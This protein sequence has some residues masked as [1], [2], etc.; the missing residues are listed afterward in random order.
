[1]RAENRILCVLIPTLLAS[2]ITIP[3]C[4]G[5]EY[6]SETRPNALHHQTPIEK[7]LQNRIAEEQKKFLEISKKKALD[8]VDP[9]LEVSVLERLALI[10]GSSSQEYILEL[11]R[12]QLKQG[13]SYKEKVKEEIKH[14][15]EIDEKSFGC[16]QASAL[17]EL[18]SSEMKI[19]LKT[20]SMYETNRDYE[21]AV[22]T[23]EEIFGKAPEE[24]T[25]RLRFYSMMGNIEGRE[26]EAIKGL[27]DIIAEDPYDSVNKMNAQKL[28]NNFT[29]LDKANTALGYLKNNQNTMLSEKLL[30]EAIA[31]T[32][33]RDEAAYWTRRLNDIRYYRYLDEADKAFEKHNLT[34]AEQLYQKASALNYASP[35]AYIGL[36][37]VSIEKHNET[38]FI[39]YANK[40]ILSSKTESVR[41]QHRIRK[42]MDGL[43]GKII[44]VKAEKALHEGDIERYIQ[45]E[46]TVATIEDDPWTYYDFAK[47]LLELNKK[48]EAFKIFDS[49]G[50]KKLNSKDFVYPYALFL[51]KADEDEQALS[52]LNRHQGES[53]DIEEMRIRLLNQKTVKDS[54]ILFDEGRKEEAY[55]LLEQ[56]STGDTLLKKAEFLAKDGKYDEAEKIIDNLL[57]EQPN[58]PD[59]L[60]N[61]IFLDI[62]QNNLAEAKLNLGKLQQEDNTLSFYQMKKYADYTDATGDKE[63]AVKIYHKIYRQFFPDALEYTP[64]K[65]GSN[66]E[67]IENEINGDKIQ[68]QNNG[69]ELSEK[70]KTELIILNNSYSDLISENKAADPDSLI[71]LNKKSLSLLTGKKYTEDNNAQ[72]T[73]DLRTSDHPVDYYVNTVKK[74][75]HKNYQQ[76]NV[77]ITDGLF[78]TL[79][80][81]HSGYSDN[82]ILTNVLNASFPLGSARGAIQIDTVNFDAG[83]LSNKSYEDA[84]GMCRATGC[85]NKKQSRTDSTVAFAYD[86]DTIH[87]DI[88]TAPKV[89]ENSFKNNDIVGAFQYK[90]DI[91]NWTIKPEIHRRA[92]DNSLLSYYGQKDPKFGRRWGGVKS[93]GLTLGSSYYY[94]QDMGFWSSVTFNTLRGYNVEN[95]YEIKAVAGI[96]KHLEDKPNE[97]LTLSPSI[98]LWHFNKNLSEY[99]YGH[100]GYYSPQKYASTSLTLSYKKRTQNWSYV[101]EGSGAIG[102][103]HKDD[104]NRYYKLSLNNSEIA[105]FKDDP[106]SKVSGDSGMSWGLSLKGAAEYRVSE[107]LVLGTALSLTKSDDYTPVNAVLYFRYYLH[108]FNG[109]L[110][111]PPAPPVPYTQW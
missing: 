69:S 57:Q 64:L 43:R 65:S 102:Y 103:V 14:L 42:S 101:I 81:G 55:R 72:Y 74:D 91:G 45:L 62:Q 25:L 76:N 12:Y 53:S 73:A 19:K 34:K 16:R 68:A 83:R 22:K 54:E 27:R 35:Y 21:N 105:R 98:M 33:D 46:R 110:P 32:T 24:H 96:Y 100:G 92:K 70:D 75:G 52:L 94:T 18:S 97:R 87:F 48:T 10:K 17:Y 8:Y 79:D 41:E 9:V 60:L 104:T 84:F 59:I 89:T 49:L 51:S 37:R 28:L 5:S 15:C 82:K 111:M 106:D 40:A 99:T 78:Y 108:D 23:L 90:Y 30:Q 2:V 61:K 109:D 36:A 50:E 39:R 86:S 63:Q 56:H 71:S 20:F 47:T 107:N 80:D 88:G 77:I 7:Q 85:E 93:T 11:I 67:L 95:N 3:Y 6:I 29:A 44:G 38:A 58:N 26:K 66:L 31:S 4:Y 1:M 13:A